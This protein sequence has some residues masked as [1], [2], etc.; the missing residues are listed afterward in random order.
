MKNRSGFVIAVIGVLGAAGMAQADLSWE[1]TITVRL[2][3]AMPC[4]APPTERMIFL[5]CVVRAYWIS[6]LQFVHAPFTSDGASHLTAPDVNRSST[7]GAAGAGARWQRRR[8]R[9]SRSRKAGA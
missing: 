5:F 2:G 1:H 8:R 4:P 6:A 7:R 3:K 9:P